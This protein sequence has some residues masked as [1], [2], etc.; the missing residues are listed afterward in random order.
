M[1]LSVVSMFVAHPV[2]GRN[3]AMDGH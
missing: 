2:D 3:Y 1:S